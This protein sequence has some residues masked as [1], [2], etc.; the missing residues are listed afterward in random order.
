MDDAVAVLTRLPPATVTWTT[1]VTCA[2]APTASV[3]IVTVTVPFEPT[4]GPTHGPGT[5]VQE[6]NLVPGGSGS[7]SVTAAAVSGPR[8]DTVTVYVRVWPGFAELLLAA[9]ETARSAPVPGRGVGV[10][11]AVAVRVAVPV[12]GVAVR[13]GVNVAVAVVVTV[14]EGVL[15]LVGVLEAVL[16]GVRVGVGVTER[17]GVAVNGAVG[18]FVAVGVGV[19]VNVLVGV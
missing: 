7:V 19:F 9:F 4:G 6:R 16:V 18:V 13:V 3:P 11:V 15:V 8:L 2:A 10:R 5:A 1:I 17:V 12:V 14:A